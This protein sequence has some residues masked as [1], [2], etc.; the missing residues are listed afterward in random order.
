MPV[1]TSLFPHSG[2]RSVVKCATQ[3]HSPHPLALFLAVGVD[4]DQELSKTMWRG[5]M[6]LYRRL[7]LEYFH[8]ACIPRLGVMWGAIVTIVD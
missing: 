8:L 7:R 6:I 5:K 2:S 3:I 1:L 4:S